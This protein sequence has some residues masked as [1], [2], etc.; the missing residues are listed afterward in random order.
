MTNWGWYSD[1]S[2]DSSVDVITVDTDY[3]DSDDSD[4]ETEYACPEETFREAPVQTTCCQTT[5]SRGTCTS[6]SG[7]QPPEVQQRGMEICG[8]T[9]HSCA[10]QR[11]NPPALERTTSGY[12][13]VPED[14]NE[15]HDQEY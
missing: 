15:G 10:D 1:C 14:W 13:C 4:L 7:V 5:T 2:S 8:P 11:S 6:L 3:L 9:G 12:F